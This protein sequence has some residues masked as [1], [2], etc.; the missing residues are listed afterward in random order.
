MKTTA[1]L[2]ITGA[3]ILAAGSFIFP[4]SIGIYIM[5]HDDA[6]HKQFKIPGHT[7]VTASVPGRYYLWNNNKTMFNGIS[8]NRAAMIP[9]GIEIL[10]SNHETEKPFRFISKTSISVSSGS[11]EKHTIGYITVEEPCDINIDING[12]NEECVFSFSRAIFMKTMG[13]FM[14]SITLS[15][16]TCLAGTAI[17]VFG[18]IKR[19]N[20]KKA[21]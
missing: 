2:I 16:I 18:I 21:S 5:H 8:Y 4:L 1:K 12:G 19:S 14:T 11:N 20:K 15:L 13:Y 6:D 3:V 7:Q 9:D 10:L 17:I